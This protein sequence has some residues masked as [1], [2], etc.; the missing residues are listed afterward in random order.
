M[1]LHKEENKMQKE[2]IGLVL[3]S[4]ER[5]EV[6][7]LFEICHEFNIPIL[8][9]ELLDDGCIHYLWGFN[10]DG[11]GLLGTEVMRRLKTI[12]HGLDEFYA[13]LDNKK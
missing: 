12:L 4:G 7:R 6:K 11:V 8:Y 5:E 10:D 9:D 1:D 3:K 2:I 13:Y